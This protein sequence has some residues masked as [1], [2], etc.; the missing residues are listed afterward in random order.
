MASVCT[1][2]GEAVLGPARGWNP[3]LVSSQAANPQLP[4]QALDGRCA[5]LPPRGPGHSQNTFLPFLFP[6]NKC[7]GSPSPLPGRLVFPPTDFQV[8]C[9][10]TSLPRRLRAAHVAVHLPLLPGTFAS[11]EA[12]APGTEERIGAL[13]LRDSAPECPQ[14]TS[15]E[16]CPWGCAPRSLSCTG[17]RALLASFL[18]APQCSSHPF[19]PRARAAPPRHSLLPTLDFLP[20]LLQM[21]TA[22]GLSGGL[23][24]QLAQRCPILHPQRALKNPA[25]VCYPRPPR[26]LQKSRL[27]KVP[28]NK[29]KASG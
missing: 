28:E 23:S 24:V 13:S 27:Q 4:R 9:V 15:E 14:P 16:V 1:L 26:D 7:P 10:D 12:A 17:H 6:G 25:Q 20:L 18:Q 3:M 8:L 22:A 2:G 11:G 21:D 5:D 19:T 29:T